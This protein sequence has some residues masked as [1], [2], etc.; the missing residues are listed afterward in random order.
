MVQY[1]FGQIDFLQSTKQYS[2]ILLIYQTLNQ[3]VHL[4][5]T[6]EHLSLQTVD[7]SISVAHIKLV[8]VR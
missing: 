5:T 7:Q 3:A 8:N 6:Y 2:Q 4:P 1:Q